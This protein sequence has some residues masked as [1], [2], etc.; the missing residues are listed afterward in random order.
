MLLIHG[1]WMTPKSWDGWAERF[2]AAGHDVTIPGWPGIDD[3]TVEDIRRNPEPLKGIGLQQI[4]GSRS[5]RKG[6]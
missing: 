2:H 1:L 3:R 4:T 5:H 6:G